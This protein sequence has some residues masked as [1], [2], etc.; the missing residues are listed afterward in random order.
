VVPL[1]WPA[2]YSPATACV[3]TRVQ[4]A[5]IEEVVFDRIARPREVRVLQPGIVRTKACC[6][7]NGR[8]VEMPFG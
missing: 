3:C 2:K 4:I 8:L 7:S 6:T 5:R 1:I